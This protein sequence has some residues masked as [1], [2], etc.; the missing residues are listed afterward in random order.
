M[1]SNKKQI[2]IRKIAVQAWYMK[3]IDTTHTAKSIMMSINYFYR[4]IED[5]EIAFLRNIINDLYYHQD[6]IMEI[7]KNYT[8]TDILDI[9]KVNLAII[10]LGAYELLYTSVNFKIIIS[11]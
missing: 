6:S 9:D 10:T 4:N 3:L 1:L 2:N 7:I 5:D 8:Y 11:F